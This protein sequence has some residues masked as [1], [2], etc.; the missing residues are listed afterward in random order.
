TLEHDAMEID[1]RLR[2]A[3]ER[4]L[5]YPSLNRRGFVVALDIVAADHVENDV[6]P[7][8]IGGRLGRGDEILRL[9]VNS[10]VGTEA[11][12]GIAFLRRAG[13]GNDARAERLGE[14]D[15]GRAD[16]PRRGLAAARLAG[17]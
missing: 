2:A 8:A 12:A 4:D 16:A 13:G 10:D 1:R 9:I 14:L 15:C 5:Y 3:L 7:L 6:C 17:P 11:A